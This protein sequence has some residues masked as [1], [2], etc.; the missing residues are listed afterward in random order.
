[1]KLKEKMSKKGFTLIEIIAVV[2]IIG[3]IALIAVPTVSQYIMSSRKS[4]YTSYEESMQDAAENQVIE[5]ISDNSN[6]DL[7]LD[8]E[9]KK[10]SLQELIDEG[11]ID[12]MKDPDSNNFC[13]SAISYVQL[14]SDSRGNYEYKA[15]LYC[16]EYVTEDKACTTYSKDG[17]DPI[18]GEVT[19]SSKRWTSQNRSVSVKC[20]DVTSGCLKSSFSKTFN[21][22]TEKGMVTITDNSGRTKDCPVDVYVDKDLPTCDI[23]V[24]GDLIESVGWY[25]LKAEATLKNMNDIGSGLLTYGI[26]SSSSNRDYNKKTNYLVDEAGITTVIGYTKDNAGNEGICAKDVRVGTEIPKFNFY[27]G[28]QIFPFVATDS[29]TATPNGVTISGNNCTTTN[30]TPTITINNTSKYKDIERL[31]ITFGSN[32]GET[33]MATVTSGSVTASAPLAAGTNKAEFVIPKGTYNSLTIKLGTL[34]GKTYNISKIEVYTT[35]GTIF[36]NKDVSVRVE[37][38]DAG[39]KTTEVSFDDGKTW[40]TNFTNTYPATTVNKIR[41]RNKILMESVPVEFRITGIDKVSPTATITA[42]KS[43]AGTTVGNG[44]WT[45]EGLNYVLSNGTVGISGA[46]IYY[47]KDTTN[48]CEPNIHT[49]SGATVT[50]Q[51]TATGIYYI[52]YRIISNA[53]TKSAVSSYTAKV[54]TV[55]PTCRITNHATLVCTDTGNA[56][57]AVSG[58]VGWYFDKTNTTTGT[59]TKINATASMNVDATSKVTSAGT[60]YLYVKDEA[61]NISNL[62]Q[63]NYYLVT[64]NKNGGTTN[65]TKASEIVRNGNKADLTPTATRDGYSFVGWNTNASASTKLSEYTVKSNVTLYAIFSICPSGTYSANS[66]TCQKC[67]P[68]SYVTGTG[69]T[70]CKACPAGQYCTG[71]D[72]QTNCP[73]GTFRSATGGKT[74]S[75]CS[76]CEAGTYTS[77]TGNTSCKKCEA[78]K[79]NNQKGQT[80]CTTC[81]A[82][83][84][85]T[86]EGNTSC[87][88]C[89]VG[90]YCTGGTNNEYCP[91]GTY[92]T[93]TGGKQKSDCTTCPAGKYCT[94]GD[95]QTNC[96]AGTYRGTTG[97]AKASDCSQCDA[98]TYTSTAG[99]TSCKKCEAGKY[100]TAKGQTSCSTC[101]AGTYNTTEGNTSCA[102]CP[103]G[104]YCTGGQNNTTCP[105]GTYRTAT[106]GK[107]ASDC[108]TCPAGKYCTG[109]TNQTTC[110]AGTYRTTTGGAKA[111][112][113]SSCP[114]GKYCT[115]GTNQTNCPAGTYRS[116]TGGKV[117]TD[118]TDCSAGTYAA[119]PGSTSCA[120]C[121]A[122]TYN[123]KPK[124]TSCST[125]PAGKYC[126][127]GQNNT[128]CPAGTYRTA[129]GGKQASDCTTCPAGKY[130]TGGT[131]QTTCPAGTYRTATGGKQASDC[132]SCPAGKYCTG[133]TNQ[134]NC[135]AG[136]YRSSTGGKVVTD[137]TDCSA[138]TYAANPGS[139]SCATC[140]AGTYNTK[141]KQTS[142]STCPAGK[143]CTGGQNNTTCP[144]G[145]YRTATGGKQA[146]DCSTCPAG[147][148]CTGGQNNTTCPAGTYRTATGG[149]QA[150][151]C[152]TCPA[153]KYC[154]G[155]T[156]QTNCPAGTYRSATGGKVVGDCTDCGAGTYSTGG[157]TSCTTCLAG[158]YNTKTK[159]SSC[160][161]CP[162][163]KYCTGGQNNT[164][165]P[166]GT[167]RT[168]TGGKALSDC[169]PCPSGKYCTGGTNQTTCPSPFSSSSSR[170]TSASNCYKTAT[171]TFNANGGSGGST[172]SCTAYYNNTYCS[173]TTPGAPT[174]AGYTFKGWSTSSTASSGTGANVNVSVSGNTTY[175]ATWKANCP[176]GY[177]TLSDGR[178]RTTYN[179][180]LEYYCPY[181]G[182]LSGTSCVTTT[183]TNADYV[184]TGYSGGCSWSKDSGHM[185]PSN[186]QSG[187]VK[188]G[189]V[190][191]CTASNVGAE[192]KVYD[193]GSGNVSCKTSNSTYNCKSSCASDMKRY[194]YKKWT[195]K[196][197]GTAQYDYVCS[198]G[199]L[200]GTQCVSSSSYPASSRYVCS[201][202]DT[203]SGTTCT[204]IINP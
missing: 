114:A 148:Y 198:S 166:A 95:N 3:I 69:N 105:A 41:T 26:G 161:T 142:C 16:G 124:Q 24:K 93:T 99:N 136:T 29:D 127:G 19:G 68:G 122:G 50:A 88:T 186:N 20:S 70:S 169:S 140:A 125:C 73:A 58:I 180:T 96:P 22:T 130:C 12:P 177:E 37:P 4:T 133:G 126:T 173:V 23:E 36:T 86:T 162:A 195:C 1:M 115:G 94:G 27:Y 191:S 192:Y 131:N 154:T 31:V 63:D 155:G 44:V 103:A 75:D 85:N 143:Y 184:Q 82:G 183:R 188:S 15:C 187:C 150:S 189:D 129:T 18:C 190:P 107:Q 104:K 49:A 201:G 97:G 194:T 123:T 200:D 33:T 134:T 152:S 159:Q 84:Y 157:S 139:T 164:T 118:C 32:V 72:N 182:S 25:S 117:V 113:C 165:C 10:V 128:T 146:S 102:T 138:G 149:K 92:R 196:C 53:G 204:K 30:T 56:T 60:Y 79:Y 109:G 185:S 45:N 64:Y 141:P 158:T 52:R 62:V 171:V 181:G 160:S 116:S 175:Y 80:S 179:A 100:N 121:A 199:Y 65:P 106:G 47:C 91:A 43:K 119:N 137:C 28:Y 17:D 168:G 153:G 147:K 11:F 61:G 39:M 178:C 66:L 89:P 5:C 176:A 74:A 7:P 87:A 108:S 67:G 54:D 101:A 203:L 34:S 77:T 170:S 71:G 145:T 135:P 6:C 57:N 202:S 21:K 172:K 46:N 90:K 48:S 197:S 167:Y 9:K 120:T 174:R 55:K 13:D 2:I 78:G 163:G 40:Q 83:T 132:S 156:N 144:A 81:A 14:T 35:N 112:D 98:G 51:N 193:C 151:D 76:Q 110:P 111:S 42:K 38:Q 8:N 59:Y